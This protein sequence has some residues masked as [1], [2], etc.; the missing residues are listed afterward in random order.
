MDVP[1]A[2]RKI[3]LD[4]FSY[5]RAPATPAARPESIVR[6]GRLLTSSA[7]ITPPSQR[8]IISGAPIFMRLTHSSVMS[9][10]S[11]IRGIRLPFITAVRV[12]TLSPY[13]WDTSWPPVDG[14]PFSP[15]SSITSLSDSGWSTPKASLAT[16]TAAPFSASSSIRLEISARIGSVSSVSMKACAVRKYFPG[17]RVMSPTSVSEAARPAKKPLP[18]PM[19]PTFATS[20]SKRAFV[21]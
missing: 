13:R 16:I 9:A 12:L 8:I 20:P 18:M 14:S 1:P 11:I 21:A 19:T 17:A 3:P 10:V 7:V 15:A 2:S 4:S 6:I 5:I